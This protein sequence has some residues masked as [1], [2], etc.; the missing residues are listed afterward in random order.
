MAGGWKFSSSDLEEWFFSH[1][2]NQLNSA[3]DEGPSVAAELYQG[4]DGPLSELRAKMKME[5]MSEVEFM[6]AVTGD[7]EALQYLLK[8]LQKE[9]RQRGTP[10]RTPHVDMFNSPAGSTVAVSPFSSPVNRARE[11]IDQEVQRFRE[12]THV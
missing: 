6:S 9:P 5:E 12:K 3:E 10:P 2:L 7:K 4:F 11:Q 8:T 1:R